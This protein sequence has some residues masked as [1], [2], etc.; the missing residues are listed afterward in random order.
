VL[1]TGLSLPSGALEQEIALAGVTCQRSGLFE[2]RSRFV[3]P[4]EFGEQIAANAG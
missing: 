2:F 3:E 1:Q 4:A